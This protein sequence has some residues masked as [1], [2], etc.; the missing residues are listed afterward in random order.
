M[1]ARGHTAQIDCFPEWDQD[2]DFADI[3][4]VLRG[5]DS[6][7]AHAD[8][9]HILWQI[10][11]GKH[12]RRRPERRSEFDA[13]SHVIFA[14]EID[15]LE[16]RNCTG[17]T[18]PS[19]VLMQ[20]FDEK[21]MYTNSNL[22]RDGILFV[23]RNHMPDEEIRP[24]VKMVVDA[25][26]SP[27]IYGPGWDHTSLKSSVKANYLPN[28][29]LGNA[30]RSA[31]IVLCDHFPSMREFGYVSNR[32]YDALACGAPVISDYVNGLPE[33]LEPHVWLCKTPADV[34]N[35]V[36]E[37]FAESESKRAARD[38]FAKALVHKHSFD[39]R[40]KQIE[41]LINDIL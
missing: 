18:S 37:I 15:G 20:A 16:E 31:K 25:G 22:K 8:H 24:I 3:D 19:S 13:A 38:A 29:E 1:E 33:E 10:Y 40:A 21:V 28:D 26:Y 35:A 32:I 12:A 7:E 23:G 11:P 30:Y 5:H 2:P 34:K 36:E 14:S 4:I 41:D 9:K 6:Y 17:F 39:V 27:K